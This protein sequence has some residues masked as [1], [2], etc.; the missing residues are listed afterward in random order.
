MKI[1]GVGQLYFKNTKRLIHDFKDGVFETYNPDI[2]REA[3]EQGFSF[4]PLPFKL[5]NEPLKEVTPKVI[6]KRRRRR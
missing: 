6:I 3:K 2:I 5:E 1:F 4:E